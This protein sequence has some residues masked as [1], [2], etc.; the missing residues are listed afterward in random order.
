MPAEDEP[1]FSGPPWWLIAPGGLLICAA[2]LFVFLWGVGVFQIQV[3]EGEPPNWTTSMVVVP[4][5]FL[6][7][8]MS[9]HALPDTARGFP[10]RKY[11]QGASV[12]IAVGTLAAVVMTMLHGVLFGFWGQDAGVS[13][14]GF[15]VNSA[16]ARSILIRLIAG[17]IVIP[18]DLMALIFLA[19][20]ISKLREKLRGE[21]GPDTARQ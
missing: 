16:W 15:S 11:A 10:L 17:V 18:M 8:F 20:G 2:C 3:T 19:I 5:F 9:A 6:G 21:S 7:L 12:I 13:V 4:F 1:R 14:F